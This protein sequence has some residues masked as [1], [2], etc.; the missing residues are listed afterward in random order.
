M[1]KFE[2][3]RKDPKHSMTEHL[4]AMSGMIRDLAAAGNVLSD[5][6]QI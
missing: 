3:Y 4:R 5:E 2:V 6:Q 1:L